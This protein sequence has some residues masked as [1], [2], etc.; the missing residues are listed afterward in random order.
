MSA[1]ASDQ[2]IACT[3]PP[4]DLKER[5]AWIAELTRDAL[6]EHRRQ[7]LQLTLVYAHAAAARVRQ[8]VRQERECCAFLTF[9]VA[10]ERDSVKVTI[11]AP[12]EARDA[13]DLLFEH[14][15]AEG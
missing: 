11:R 2:P 6:I 4:G 3:L 15:V 7:G 1:P 13:A 14:F 12:E 9:D 8:M 10:E 5:F